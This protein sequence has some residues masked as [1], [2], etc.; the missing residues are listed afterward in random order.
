MYDISSFQSGTKH[1]SASTPS[2]ITSETDAN[3]QT[4]KQ[5]A[6]PSAPKIRGRR[7]PA[8]NIPNRSRARHQPAASNTVSTSKKV[9]NAKEIS[10]E[11]DQP[12]GSVKVAVTNVADQ[13]AVAGPPPVQRVVDR[14][15]VTSMSCKFALLVLSILL[16]IRIC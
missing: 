6:A 9:D 12:S 2:G 3:K 13:S 11:T 1:A 16:L 8:P 14:S 15:D 5:A 7:K 4:E 10:K